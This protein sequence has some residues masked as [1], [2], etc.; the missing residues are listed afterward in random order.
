MK[1]LLKQLI[2]RGCKNTKE[3]KRE[4]TSKQSSRKELEIKVEKGAERAFNEYRGA[5]KKLAE[6][7]R[8]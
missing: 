4:E 6:Y 7:D 1:N 3:I 2:N 8:S 5:F